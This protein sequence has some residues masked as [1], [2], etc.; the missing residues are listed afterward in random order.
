MSQPIRASEDTFS[1]YS[2]ELTR[3]L[4]SAMR[5][6]RAESTQSIRICDDC[7]KTILPRHIFQRAMDI[8]HH[9]NA[10]INMMGQPAADPKIIEI[11]PY[12]TDDTNQI[13][14]RIHNKFEDFSK[15]SRMI[16]DTQFTHDHKDLHNKKEDVRDSFNALDRIE[17]L[18]MELGSPSVQPN[19][20]LRR[21]NMIRTLVQKLCTSAPC[22]SIS[23]KSP[24]PLAFIS[25]IN[26]F[27]EAHQLIMLLDL[28]A[29]HNGLSIQGGITVISP[30]SSIITPRQVNRLCG[31]LLA[32]LIALNYAKFGPGT[33]AVEEITGPAS[34]TQVWQQINYARRLLE[35]AL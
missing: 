15:L 9:L 11:R 32:D 2:E 1:L 20:V 14:K 21:A 18:L 23:P 17:I 22:S 26:V 25:P 27:N 6:M 7:S 35:A 31:V 16:D 29:H 13:I 19:L 10:F 8:E 3:H 12:N 28:F 30:S 5:K 34:P 24:A 33:I 4:V